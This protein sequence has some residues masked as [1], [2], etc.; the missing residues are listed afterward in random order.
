M[1]SKQIT[2]HIP[3]K[4]T[5]VTENHTIFFFQKQLYLYPLVD[6]G[7]LILAVLQLGIFFILIIRSAF[8]KLLIPSSSSFFS[9]SGFPKFILCDVYSSCL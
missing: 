3:K 1:S 2:K 8:I 9:P 4:Y 6:L 5:T 7:I